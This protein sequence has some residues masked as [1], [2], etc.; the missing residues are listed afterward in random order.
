MSRGVIPLRDSLLLFNTLSGRKEPFVPLKPG[1]VSMVVCGPTVQSRIHMGHARTFV[2]YDVVARYLK[3]LGYDVDYVMNI[4]D[5]DE[6]ITRAAGKSEESPFALARRFFDAFVEDMASLKCTSISRFEPASAH[7]ETMMQQVSALVAKGMAYAVDGWVYFDT[8]KFRRFGRL[9]HQ[10]KMELSL[11]PLELSARKRH[12]TDFALWRP[13]V[14]VRGMWES[15]WG[16]GS[17]GWHIQD[18]AVTI[19]LFGSQHDIH[20]GALELVYP[21]HEAQIAQAES[22]TGIRP[23]VRYWVHTHHVNMEGKK[24]SKSVGNIL[25]VR[26]AL[27]NFSASQIRF[28]LLKTHYRRDMDLKG[29]KAAS[30]Q[31]KK[32][33]R[34]AASISEDSTRG[35]RTLADARPLAEFMAAMND[36][37]DTPGAIASVERAL[38]VGAKERSVGRRQAVLAAAVSSMDILGVELIGNS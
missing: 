9:S 20:G 25:T 31:L 22:L 6:T 24:M 37:F 8:S 7:I 2:F 23:F 11:R 32:M 21:H 15:P 3:R 33:R 13:D 5:F 26:E 14:L 36:D 34:T 29:M 16:L 1:K 35:K 27:M 12:V 4:T 38:E 10:S 17:P 28:F 18:T 19:P 30:G